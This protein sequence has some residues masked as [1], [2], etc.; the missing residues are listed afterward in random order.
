M[1]NNGQAKDYISTIWN[2]C[3]IRT[4]PTTQI[5]DGPAQNNFLTTLGN[6]K[7]PLP[8]IQLAVRD[9]STIVWRAI[10]PKGDNLQPV[11]T[12]W[13]LNKG[14]VNL[15]KSEEDKATSKTSPQSNDHHGPIGTG[16]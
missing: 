7:A 9:V 12:L 16:A 2:D 8:T 10:S 15:E 1:K 6:Q 11:M 5:G 14:W 3:K 4:Q 13:G